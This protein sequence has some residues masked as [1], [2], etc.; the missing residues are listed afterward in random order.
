MPSLVGGNREIRDDGWFLQVHCG[1]NESQGAC[2]REESRVIGAHEIYWG[3]IQYSFS[4]SRETIWSTTLVIHLSQ[5]AQL[6]GSLS[7]CLF[8]PSWMQWTEGMS[9]NPDSAKQFSMNGT[10]CLFSS[11]YNILWFPIHTFLPSSW[12]LAQSKHVRFL[13]NRMDCNPKLYSSVHGILQK[14]ILERGFR[15]FPSPTQGLDP[16]SPELYKKFL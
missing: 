4:M 15:C 5:M 10:L 1:D 11:V 8:L 7:A 3:L 12:C 16:V 13:S 14:R 2:M 9:L 6:A